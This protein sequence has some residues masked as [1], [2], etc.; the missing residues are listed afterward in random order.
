MLR[1]QKA[2][3]PLPGAR[4]ERR[5]PRWRHAVNAAA[6]ISRCACNNGHAG[7]MVVGPLCDVTPDAGAVM[8]R[9]GRIGGA[10]TGDAAAQS[11]QGLDDAEGLT[12]RKA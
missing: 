3:P 8:N 6:V 12:M 7:G 4:S 11:P 2:A 10:A 9:I 5:L 1:K